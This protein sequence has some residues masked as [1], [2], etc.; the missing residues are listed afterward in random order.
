MTHIQKLTVSQVRS[1]QR[2]VHAVLRNMAAC[3]LK[4]HLHGAWWRRSALCVVNGADSSMC[5]VGELPTA[6]HEFESALLRLN[7]DN[8]FYTIAIVN[9]PISRCPQTGKALHS[10]QWTKGRSVNMASHVFV[11][12]QSKTP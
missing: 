12:V 6:T 4:R 11:H 10:S 7:L 3:A 1:A 5:S 2:R 8:S 9:R